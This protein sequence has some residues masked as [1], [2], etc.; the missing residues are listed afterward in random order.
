MKEYIV[1]QVDA[2][3]RTL[4]KGNP[5]GVVLNADGLSDAAMQRIARELNN[6]ETAFLFLPDDHTC[7]GMIRYFTPTVEVPTC[8]H[9][10]VA[11]MYAMA[12][13][14][15]LGS[16]VFRMKTRIGVL[17]FEVLK[18]GRG[19]KVVMTQGEIK[20]SDPLSEKDKKQLLGLLGL[21]SR[22]IDTRCPVQI[23]STG[24]AKVM[25]GITDRER[26]NTLTPDFN[27][28][29]RFSRTIDCTGYFVF[30]LQSDS[31]DILSH[32]R[33]FAPAIGIDE[34]PVTGNANGPLGAYLVHNKIVDTA[35]DCL[36]FKGKQGETLGREGIVEVKV[37]IKNRQ[38]VKV[39]IMGEAA[40]VF[41]TSI[42]IETQSDQIRINK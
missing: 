42:Q 19:Y 7:D 21:N 26:L 41:R 6:S 15:G 40:I 27:G 35:A 30:T 25:I 4:F 10:T 28:L 3:T 22:D 39:R 13:E 37:D 14:Q 12:L 18:T 9:A 16:R 38:P 36:C 5:A 17:P 23:A 32:G 2:F 1:Y 24:H 20:I 11:A 8:G 33:M 34:D 31:P 29:K